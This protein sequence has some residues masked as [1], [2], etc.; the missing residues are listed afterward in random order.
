MNASKAKL[1]QIIGKINIIVAGKF[2]EDVEALVKSATTFKNDITTH[3]SSFA[4]IA[5]LRNPLLTEDPKGKEAVSLKKGIKEVHAAA[6]QAGLK[7]PQKLLDEAQQHIPSEKR[8]AP[9]G[10]GGGRTR[11]RTA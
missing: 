4:L 3:M 5:C 7:V 10:E 2:P 6:T 1:E 9:S 11:R 8:K